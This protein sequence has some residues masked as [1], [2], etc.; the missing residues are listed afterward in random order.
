M[1]GGGGETVG[2]GG[3][4]GKSYLDKRLQIAIKQPNVKNGAGSDPPG[5]SVGFKMPTIQTVQ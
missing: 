5:A 4:R 1:G 2:G 3:G